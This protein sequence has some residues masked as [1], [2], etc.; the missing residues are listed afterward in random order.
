MRSRERLPGGGSLLGR[1][2]VQQPPHPS[3]NSPMKLRGIIP[4]IVTP[5][6]ADQEVDLPGMR[7]LI[8]LMLARGV[9]G[10]FVL[11]TTG[12]FYALDEREKRAIVADAIAHVGGRSP[13]YAGT[14]AETTREVIRLTKMAEQ[15][16]AAG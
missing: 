15:E 9:H 11:G 12:E 5:M 7:K 4:P 8:D 13:V 16:G 1:R 10:I 3:G 6:T 2:L 14:G